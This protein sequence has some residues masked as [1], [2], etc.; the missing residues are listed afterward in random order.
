NQYELAQKNILSIP[1]T[2]K[3]AFDYYLIGLTTK[4]TREAIKA[5]ENAIAL[6]EKFAET[7]S[8]QSISLE[9]E[10]EENLFN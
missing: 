3:I 1:D 8:I 9:L 10:G 4:D 6:D 5:Y 7:F 2:Q